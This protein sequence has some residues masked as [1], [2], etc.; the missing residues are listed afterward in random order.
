[1]CLEVYRQP[2]SGVI[3]GVRATCIGIFFCSFFLLQKSV[4]SQDTIPQNEQ[5][6]LV[7]AGGWYS[8]L[9]LWA[10]TGF[11]NV[12]VQPACKIWVLRPQAGI[13]VSFSGS[14]MVYA[15]LT[16]PAEPLKWLVIQTGAALGYYESGK[17]VNL[18][19]PLEFRLSLS[20]L[21]KFRNSAQLGLEI[22][23]ISN[24]NL[25]PPNPGTESVSVIFQL[26]I[27]KQIP[28]NNGL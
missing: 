20:V 19:F 22:A 27:R 18:A 1:M 21:Y 10:S 12:Q 25:G 16:W 26:P 3:P 24:A 9:D 6:Y 5:G 2:G 8:C 7:L 14:Y 17:G 28:F 11:V 13:L 23:H 4:I 15:G